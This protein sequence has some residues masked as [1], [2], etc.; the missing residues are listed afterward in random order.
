MNL[1]VA[2]STLSAEARGRL[3]S[4]PGEPL[5]LADWDR[6]LMIHFRVDPIEL[7]RAVPF[8]LDLRRGDAYVS[9]VAFTMTGMRLRFGHRWLEWLTKPIA[10]HDFLNVR[11]YVRCGGESGILFLAE[12]LTNRLSVLLGP[13]VFGLPYRYGRIVYRH[14]PERGV[15][16]GSVEDNTGATFEYSSPI[17]A[18]DDGAAYSTA[19]PGSL[20][21]W[22]MERYT[23]FTCVNGKRRFFRVWHVPWPQRS[24]LVEMIAKS[25]LE[26]N[27]GFFEHAECVGANYSPGVKDVWM[28]W[29]HKMGS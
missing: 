5:F 22:L 6:A 20:T 18:E 17:A 12:W 3:L 25:L 13:R 26:S 15:L 4:L 1:A 19:E 11:T 10:S 7:Q 16:R 23:A 2:S 21:E 24:V 9:A 14:N 8:D 28:G 29:P 27:W